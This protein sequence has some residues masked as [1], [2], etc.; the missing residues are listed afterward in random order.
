MSEE[1]ERVPYDFKK[2]Y[3]EDFITERSVSNSL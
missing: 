1:L 2:N 3:D